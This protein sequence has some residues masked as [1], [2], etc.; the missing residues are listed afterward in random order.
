ML[1]RDQIVHLLNIKGV[2]NK[3]IYRMWLENILFSEL[4]MLYEYLLETTKNNTRYHLS[5]YSEFIN[6]YNKGELIFEESKRNN[7]YVIT[8][9]DSAYPKRLKVIPNPPLVLFIKGNIECINSTRS[10][11]IIGTRKPTEYGKKLARRLGEYFAK[12]NYVV[13]SGL[14]EGCDTEAHL[15][16]LSKKG[17]TVAVL[18]HGL[19]TIYPSIN[20]DLANDILKYNGCLVSEY[21]FGV[22]ARPSYFVDRD[23]IQSGLSDGV[24]VVETGINSGT[25]HTVKFCREQKRILACYKHP[26]KYRNEPSIMGNLKLLNEDA[27]AIEDQNSLTE[28]IRKMSLESN[29]FNNPEKSSNC[30]ENELPLFKSIKE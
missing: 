10:V 15:G 14:A 24:L 16:C 26:D 8:I 12:S 23:R 18:A 2:G 11:A 6:E 3:T 21:P 20:K 28:F 19:D 13:V 7:I 30:E 17:Q 9:A 29:I 25:M 27:I 4:H 1:D 22:R 5:E